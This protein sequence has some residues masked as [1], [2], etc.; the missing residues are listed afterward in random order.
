[1]L[2][3]QRIEPAA[4][5]VDDGDNDHTPATIL[6]CVVNNV[7]DRGRLD[8]DSLVTTRCFIVKKWMFL[9]ANLLQLVSDINNPTEQDSTDYYR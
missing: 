5:I 1:M 8:R 2:M 6:P 4:D 7:L 3:I 9:L